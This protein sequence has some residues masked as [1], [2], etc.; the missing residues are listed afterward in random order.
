MSSDVWSVIVIVS[1]VGWITSTL[2]F[3]F[4]AFPAKD[5]F[6]IRPAR[7]WG[8]CTLLFYALWVVGLVNA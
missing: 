3:I 4:K 6:E 5:R 7:V 2:L 8:G 1:L